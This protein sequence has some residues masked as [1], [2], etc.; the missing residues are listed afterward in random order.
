MNRASTATEDVQCLAEARAE[1][2][3]RLQSRWGDL[4]DTVPDD[5]DTRAR[6]LDHACLIL[7]MV[8]REMNDEG[9]HVDA[10]IA[11]MARNRERRRI[12]PRDSVSAASVLHDVVLDSAQAVLPAPY[13]EMQLIRDLSRACTSVFL[14]ILIVSAEE[15]LGAL[16]EEVVDSH[17]AERRRISRELHDRTGHGL[18]VAHRNL[19]LVQLDQSTGADETRSEVAI[20]TAICS[21]TDTMRGIRSMCE[22]LR[23]DEDI[24]CFRGAIGAYLQNNPGCAAVTVTV[25][26]DEARV[27]S[28]IRSEAFLMI[29][30]T[31][32]NAQRHARASRIVLTVSIGNS[33]LDVS[34][35]D[36]GVGLLEDYEPG[37]GMASLHERASLLGGRLECISPPRGGTT[38]LIT[39]PLPS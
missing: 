27:P 36:N 28:A 17:A 15:H 33:V 22:G 1:M 25:T 23:D 7:E 2:L 39:I 14:N 12:H 29:R 6:V 19:E 34:T 3:T 35:V 21:I 38:V 11:E 10:M 18:A 13:G 20:D 9:S 5:E 26:G 32:R 8:M 37:A 31:L 4:P 16:L 30:E 24:V